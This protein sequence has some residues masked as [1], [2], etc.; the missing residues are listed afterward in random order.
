MPRRVTGCACGVGVPLMYVSRRTGAGLRRG[1]AR[2]GQSK[3]NGARTRTG[4][5]GVHGTP[6]T[7]SVMYVYKKV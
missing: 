1:R 4:R 7:S 5:E 2:R 3:A 6:T